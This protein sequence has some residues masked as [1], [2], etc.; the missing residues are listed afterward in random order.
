MMADRTASMPVIVA[1]L[2][3]CICAWSSNG[4]A[5]CGPGFIYHCHPYEWYGVATNLENLKYSEISL[6]MENL[7]NSQGKNRKKQSIFS[8]SF[9]YLVRL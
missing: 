1:F 9:K 2:I 8:S 6:N 7:G 3:M 4:L 5:L